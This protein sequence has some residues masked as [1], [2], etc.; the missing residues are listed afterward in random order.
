MAEVKDALKLASIPT[1]CLLL[2]AIALWSQQSADKSPCKNQRNVRS[3]TDDNQKIGTSLLTASKGTHRG[4][5][6]ISSDCQTDK[7][8][9]TEAVFDALLVGIGYLQWTI[10]SQ[11]RRD[12]VSVNQPFVSVCRYGVSWLHQPN[13]EQRIVS[14][15][16][17]PV[18]ENSGNLAATNLITWVNHQIFL[19]E[20]PE[21][22][23]F[24]DFGVNRKLHPVFIRP[25]GTIDAPASEISIIPLVGAKKQRVFVYIWGWAEYADQMTKDRL[26]RIEFCNRILV[27][28]DPRFRDC[29]FSFPF[30]MRHNAE[31]DYCYRRPGV[32]APLRENPNL[33][34]VPIPVEELEEYGIERSDIP[35]ASHDPDPAP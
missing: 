11:M 20:I 25:H 4:G 35:G 27:H 30:H 34:M 28:G 6:A 18:F 17:V 32:R 24:P 3:Q 10:Y 14:W 5:N 33:I 8:G 9:W 23:D 13:N 21:E 1:V 19:E 26:H 2:A 7:K 15:K 29:V 16:F 12:S 22:F 31:G